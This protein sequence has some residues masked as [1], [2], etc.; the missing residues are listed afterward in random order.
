MRIR[1]QLLEALAPQLSSELIP[2][3]YA[4]AELITDRRRRA[5]VL[6]SLAPHLAAE[7]LAEAF[8]VTTPFANERRMIE[9]QVQRLSRDQQAIFLKSLAQAAGRLPRAEALELVTSSLAYSAAVGGG[10]ALESIYRSIS[11][12]ALWYP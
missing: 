5:V 2:E 8:V 3:A 11:D 10:E 1:A 6:A 9:V 4:A 7:Q 12:T